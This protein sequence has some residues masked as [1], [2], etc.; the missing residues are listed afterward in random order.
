MRAR[1]TAV[2]A[3]AA[4]VLMA[5]ACGGILFYARRA[6][7]RSAKETLDAAIA[8]V[9]REQHGERG[10]K[11]LSRLLDEMR[12]DLRPEGLSLLLVADDGRIVRSAGWSPASGALNDGRA[13]RTSR[14]RAG[15]NWLVVAVPWSK[16]ESSLRS[17][18]KTLLLLAVFVVL[19]ATVGAWILVGRTLSP[20]GRLSRQ[21][22]SV[23]IEGLRVRLEAPSGDAEIV[24]LVATLNGLLARLSETASAKGRFYS[25]ASHELRTPLQALSGHLEL[26]LRKDRTPEEYRSAVAE[27]H[28]QARRLIKL[29]HDLLLL[30]HL[31]SSE[32]APEAEPG[33]LS[34]ICRDT[35]AEF[36]LLAAERG[37]RVTKELPKQA[38][39]S[40]PA[41][42]A[43][44]MVRNLWEN[45]LRYADGGREVSVRIR[46]ES[47]RLTLSVFNACRLPEDWSPER[48]FEPF[49]RLDPSR[50]AATGGTGLGLAICKAIADA[51]D[52]KLT[53][54]R[55]SNGVLATL[56]I[57]HAAETKMANG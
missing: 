45:A 17:L 1:T 39:F 8:A 51:N 44:M 47:D 49:A 43:E 12:E 18:T 55:E 33:D 28:R 27:G 5:L 38:D 30:Y 23:T 56:V 25:A 22:N 21:A 31:D 29:T 13:W 42:H 11:S 20:I 19:V 54:A 37:L 15:E 3:V 41:T 50:T 53:L 16:T 57:P 14:V 52:W 48:L 40:A 46:S 6:A 32:K 9:G 34:A 7:E 35:L 10:M 26:A 2:F 36:A 24:G 4:A